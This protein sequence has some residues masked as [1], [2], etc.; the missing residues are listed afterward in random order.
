[1]RYCPI[2]K[3][4]PLN[5][6]IDELSERTLL[7][8]HVTGMWCPGAV[9][10]PARAGLEYLAPYSLNISVLPIPLKIEAIKQ[11]LPY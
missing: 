10:E 5:S 2:L 4:D 8:R 6:V 3:I 9:V 7:F 11:C 1:M